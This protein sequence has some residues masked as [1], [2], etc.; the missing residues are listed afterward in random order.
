MRY[1]RGK[2]CYLFKGDCSN[3]NNFRFKSEYGNRYYPMGGYDISDHVFIWYQNLTQSDAQASYHG[4]I[5]YEFSATDWVDNDFEFIDSDVSIKTC[6]VSP[7]YD[8][9]KEF[10]LNRK[11]RR[12]A[13][14]DD[15]V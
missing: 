15:I 1:L 13:H 4:R 7:V 6:G 5:V 2:L 3:G 11:R 12:D 8:S 9:K 14:V 10:R